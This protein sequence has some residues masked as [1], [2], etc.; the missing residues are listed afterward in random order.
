MFKIQL[1]SDKQHFVCC[2]AEVSSLVKIIYYK[3][4]I[5]YN[6]IL[7][8]TVMPT[9]IIWYL[10]LSVKCSSLEPLMPLKGSLGNQ[11]R[12]FYGNLFL[13]LYF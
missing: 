11:K 9:S 2:S 13:N 3:I 5:I 10:I 7:L 12:F 1:Y 4:M 6:E 8:E